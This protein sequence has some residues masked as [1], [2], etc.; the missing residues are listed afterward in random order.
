MAKVVGEV[1]WIRLSL[2]HSGFPYNTLK[3]TRERVLV[4]HAKTLHLSGVE[5]NKI[6]H[7]LQGNEFT[8]KF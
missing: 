5:S 6:N 8:I 2:C 4:M 7:F 1:R 3:M